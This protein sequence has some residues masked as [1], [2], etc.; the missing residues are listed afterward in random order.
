MDP[1][2]KLTNFNL[3]ILLK[4]KLVFSMK[5]YNISQTSIIKY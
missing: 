1:L 2:E 5:I 3:K 4:L